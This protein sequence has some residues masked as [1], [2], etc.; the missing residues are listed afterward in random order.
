MGFCVGFFL[1]KINMLE[2]LQETTMIFRE[3]QFSAVPQ[4]QGSCKARVE[5]R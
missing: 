5:A 3:H 1:A 2:A 4:G